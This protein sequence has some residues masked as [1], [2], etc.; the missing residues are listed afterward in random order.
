MATRTHLPTN[1]G[2]GRAATS[3]TTRRRNRVASNSASP[4]TVAIRSVS[5][6]STQPFVVDRF[7]DGSVRLVRNQML[8]I[9]KH[10]LRE[11]FVS[12]RRPEQEP[13]DLGL[14][15]HV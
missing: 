5:A 2:N 3:W 7:R 14:V 11:A 12:W 9:A 8:H 6:V 10:S 4:T 13:D 15:D 1:T